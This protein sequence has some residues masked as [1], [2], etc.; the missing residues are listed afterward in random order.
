MRYMLW[1]IL[2]FCLLVPFHASAGEGYQAKFEMSFEMDPEMLQA[3]AG[4]D[5]PEGFDPTSMMP[6]GMSGC[7]R[8]GFL[9]I[10][11]KA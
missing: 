5:M 8:V 7:Q 3:M 1:A 6:S 10:A 4:E 11:P 2:L 9:R